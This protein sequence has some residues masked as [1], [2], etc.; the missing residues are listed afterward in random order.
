MIQVLIPKN[1]KLQSELAMGQTPAILHWKILVPLQGFTI[2]HYPIFNSAIEL[3]LFTLPYNSNNSDHQ[4]FQYLKSWR[5]LPFTKHNFPESHYNI[6]SIF[7]FIKNK[8]LGQ[9]YGHDEDLSFFDNWI[10][11][12][13]IEFGKINGPSISSRL[14]LRINFDGFNIHYPPFG[15]DW[16]CEKFEINVNLEI[17]DVVIQNVVHAI[18]ASEVVTIGNEALDMDNYHF[19]SEK[20][21][22]FINAKDTEERTVYT[23]RPKL[24]NWSSHNKL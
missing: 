22:I 16:Y 18:S 12:D 24:T 11:I 9:E 1:G 7:Y 14:L 3:G 6:G 5:E 19:V 21:S 17:E 13:A 15:A 2:G 8:L 10:D 20:K 4:R 23:F